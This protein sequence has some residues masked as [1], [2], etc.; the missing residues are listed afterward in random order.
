VRGF[1]RIF[2]WILAAV[3]AIVSAVLLVRLAASVRETRHADSA[4]VVSAIRKIAQLATVEAQISDVLR[5]EEV[6][7]FLIFDFPKTATIRMRGKVV[8]GFDLS[9]PDFSVDTDAGKRTIRVRLPAPRILALDPR[10]EWFDEQ[11]GLFNPIT[12]QDRTRWMLWARGQLG[13]AAKDSGIEATA[14]EHA[15]ELLAG[16]AEAFGWKVEVTRA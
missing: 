3:F 2:P 4:P 14:V 12:P 9:S 15:R 8:A 13:R 7:S 6:K 10:L 5:F 11:S 1:A 16:V